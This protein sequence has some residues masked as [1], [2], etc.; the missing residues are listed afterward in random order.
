MD[1]GK[2]ERGTYCGYGIPC[3]VQEKL[4]KRKVTKM[5]NDEDGVFE[6]IGHLSK[7]CQKSTFEA[8]NSFGK[9]PKSTVYSEFIPNLKR[10]K[11]Q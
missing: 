8:K 1:R 6:Y 9:W 10:K 4:I 5:T 3:N 2:I 7:T 11:N